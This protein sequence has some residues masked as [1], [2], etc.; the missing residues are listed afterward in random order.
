[1]WNDG[2]LGYFR[3]QGRRG[4]TRI[5]RAMSAFAANQHDENADRVLAAEPG[6]VGKLRTTCVATMLRG[7]HA[8]NAL[9]QTRDRHGQLPHFPG[10]RRRRGESHAGG[11][12]GTEVEVKTIGD[13]PGAGSRRCARTCSTR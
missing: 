10:H 1:M 5:G 9:P 6:E 11:L 7:G 8:E 2:T 3:A 4:T 12:A 13:L